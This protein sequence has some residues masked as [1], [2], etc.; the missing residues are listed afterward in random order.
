LAYLNLLHALPVYPVT[1]ERANPRSRLSFVQRISAR[2]VILCRALPGWTTGGTTEV[3]NGETGQD[4]GWKGGGPV[5]IVKG[6]RR[7][8]KVRIERK[9]VP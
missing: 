9:N 1:H 4:D 5:K 7:L 2:P 8:N 6:E 3:T